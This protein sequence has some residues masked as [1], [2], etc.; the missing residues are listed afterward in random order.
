MDLKL[1]I[2]T[3]KINEYISQQILDSGVGEYLKKD[4]NKVI[5][6]YL[7]GYNSP[8]KKHVE[9]VVFDVIKGEVEKNK[10][11]IAQAVLKQMSGKLITKIIGK[12]IEQLKRECDFYD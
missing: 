8:I 5:K 1:N 3:E 7:E 12:G 6:D 11:L 9:K 2:S 4:L 10:D